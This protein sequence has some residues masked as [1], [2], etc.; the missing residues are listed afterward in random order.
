MRGQMSGH[1]LLL[2]TLLWRAEHIFADKQIVTRTAQG[3]HRYTYAE[4]ARRTRHLAG[5]LAVLGV[6][7]G[8]RVGTLAWNTWRH[9]EA[10]YAVPCIGAVLH[11]VNLRLAPA[12]IAQIISH[13][14]DEVLLIDTDQVPL[15]ESLA[16]R[17]PTVRHFVVLDDKPPQTPA[18]RSCRVYEELIALAE[19]VARFPVFDEN[20]ASGLCYTS[21]TTGEPKGVLYSHRSMVLHSLALCAHTSVGIGEEQRTLLITPMFHVNAWGVPHAAVMQGTELVLPGIHPDVDDYVALL[22]Q[23]A[24]TGAVGAVTVGIM[25]REHLTQSGQRRRLESFTRLWLGGQAV[26]EGLSRW[27]ADTLGV[28]VVQG[29][30]MTEASPLVTFSYLKAADRLAGEAAVA[31]ATQGLP[32]PLVELRLEAEDGSEL[33][34][35]GHTRGEVVLR[36]P[37]IASGYYDGPAGA[38]DAFV[39]GWYRSGDIASIDSRGYVTVADRAKDMIK[40]GGEWISS[41]QLENTLIAHPAVLEAAVV[42]TPHP[43]WLER[44][45]AVLVLRDPAQP[46]TRET[47]DEFLL[48]RGI[49]RWSLPDEYIFVQEVPK[50]GVGKFDKKRIRAELS[51]PSG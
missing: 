7:D 15:V 46:P 19:P 20:T 2:S 22:E 45:V 18:M 39:D 43:K 28:S 35:D 48:S 14:G 11:T 12:Q 17:L 10:Y 6:T 16:D 21:A 47:L 25:L 8:T 27:F 36:S 9:L 5:A 29:L 30:G 33:P 44:P 31:S 49:V 1:P 34:W 32:L 24:C 23:E 13:A 3:T 50:T 42:A 4:F 38:A 40:S 41:I 51:G 37:W 26:P